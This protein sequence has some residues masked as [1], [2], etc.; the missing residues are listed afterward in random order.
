MCTLLVSGSAER[1]L[2]LTELNSDHPVRV[3]A[4][5]RAHPAL[6]KLAR[7]C[8]ALA[9]LQLAGETPPT[10]SAADPTVPPAMQSKEDAA[11]SGKEDRH[12]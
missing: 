9:L 2:C 11:A 7:A 3:T 6:K 12:A 4:E 8:I 10:A 1:R 5:Q